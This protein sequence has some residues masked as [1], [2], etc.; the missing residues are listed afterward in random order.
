MFLGRLL[1]RLHIYRSVLLGLASDEIFSAS[2]VNFPDNRE[3]QEE[4]IQDN[5]CSDEVKDEVG[6]IV[7]CIGVRDVVREQEH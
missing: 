1:V 5:I 4:N 2:L 7:A 3:D 6:Q